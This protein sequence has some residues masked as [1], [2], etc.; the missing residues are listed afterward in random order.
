[1]SR[2]S[3]PPPHTFALHLSSHV[4]SQLLFYRECDVIFP[5]TLDTARSTLPSDGNPCERKKKKKHYK[6]LISGSLEAD[7]MLSLFYDVNEPFSPC[8][9]ELSEKCLSKLHSP[10]V[11]IDQ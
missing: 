9:F 8:K 5:W 11:E 10:R 4:L 6:L 3:T 1:M 2:S 7:T